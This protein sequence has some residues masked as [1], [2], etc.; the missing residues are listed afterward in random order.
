MILALVAKP[1]HLRWLSVAALLGIV[2]GVS[3]LILS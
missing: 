3:L 2:G 1:A